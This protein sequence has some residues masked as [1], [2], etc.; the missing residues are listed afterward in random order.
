MSTKKLLKDYIDKRTIDLGPYPDIIENG[1]NTISGE[2]PFKL[3]LAITLAELITFSSH[4]RKPIQL[5]DGTLVPTNA[6]VF[7]L[8]ASGTSKD[9]SLNTLRKSLATGYEHLEDQ[10]KE[11]ARE[12]AVK[13]A[14]L[15]GDTEHDWQKHYVAPKPLQAGL[16]T[17]EG[18]MHHFADIAQNP[19][20]AGSILSSE[21]GSEL[22]TN[23]AIVD[24]I[25]IIA[26]A[27]DLGNI[28]PKIVKSTEN[29]TGAV[30]NLP[31]N[32]LFFGSQEAILYNNEIKNKFRLVFNTQLARRSIFTFTPEAPQKLDIKTIDELYT[33]KEAER[34]RVLSA[35]VKL[36]ALTADLVEDTTRTPLSVADEAQKLFDV[37]LEYNSIVSDEQS[38][39]YPISKLSRKHKQWLALKLAGTYAILE[40]E[41]EVTEEIFAYAINTVEFL[42]PDMT[43]FEKELVKE[44]YEQ[45]S[46]MCRYKAEEGEFFLSL[47]ELRKLSY[48][49]GT[50]ASRSKV[51]EMI[52]LANSYDENGSYTMSEGG[53]QYRELVQTDVVGV[54]YKIF[55]MNSA[56][57]GAEIK[58][59]MARNSSSGYEFYETNFEELELLLKE[60]ACYCSFAFTDGERKKEN[61]YGGTKFVILDIDKS[62]LT[63]IEAHHLL[64]EYN[65]YVVRTSDPDNE[66]KFRVILELDSIVDIDERLWKVFIEE[67]AD[68]L[69][70]V[71]DVL[72]QSQI[73]LSFADRNILSQMGGKTVKTKFILENAAL[74]M[75]DKPKPAAQLPTKDKSLKLED[76]RETFN[77]AFEA[78]KGERSIKIY[79]ALALA[80]DLGATEE[81]IKNLASEINSYYVEPMS[82]DRLERT[83]VTPALRRL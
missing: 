32:A 58:E 53:I 12:K 39:K 11:Y 21:I 61:L 45:L 68:E 30:K 65:H 23:G 41:T 78:D 42:S 73:F 25:K 57:T 29:Q 26:V 64:N 10:R 76:P 27:Y 79:R 52:T 67:L 72:P 19:M 22:Q 59:Y 35:Q 81:Y 8:S 31:V 4:L 24:I 14:I 51:E 1:I 74:R 13:L 34:K 47:H 28:P 80:I 37:Y 60:N 9:K 7:A 56:E 63:D 48:I 44:P 2:V 38:G 70:L 62:M 5:H 55:Q 15:E 50:G 36:N 17:V 71:I 83:L 43:E 40:N 33:K 18:L 46:D 16:G 69:G 82:D 77:F 75:K 3:K 49:T 54:S 20:G 66:F 6:I